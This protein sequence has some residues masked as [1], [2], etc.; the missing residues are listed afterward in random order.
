MK[1]TTSITANKIMLTMTAQF[2][3][4]KTR[5]VSNPCGIDIAANAKMSPVL[6]NDGI[7]ATYIT[8]AMKHPKAFE[9][10]RRGRTNFVKMPK[11]KVTKYRMI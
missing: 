3:P 9:A 8:I 2:G 11:P 1:P 5:A 7:V 10:N 6:R 4:I